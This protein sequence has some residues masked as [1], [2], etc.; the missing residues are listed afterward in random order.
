MKELFLKVLARCAFSCCCQASGCKQ[1]STSFLPTTG[2][3]PPDR[4]TFKKQK[5]Q[6]QSSTLSFQPS[7][8]WEG[9]GVGSSSPL[10][11][12][13]TTGLFFLFLPDKGIS[14]RRKV[15][16]FKGYGRRCLHIKTMSLEALQK[17]ERLMTLSGVFDVF[18]KNKIRV[19]CGIRA[20]RTLSLCASVF[21]NR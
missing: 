8:L 20:K 16:G 19:I 7:S 10:H 11:T 12:P 5:Q 2:P 17:A 6:K 15:Q 14:W 4:Q 3:L 18:V 1:A 13:N 21:N 9:T